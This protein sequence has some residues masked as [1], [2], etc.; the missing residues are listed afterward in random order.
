[1]SV[2]YLASTSRWRASLLR[3]CGLRVQ[4]ISP[5]IDEKSII[6]DSPIDTAILRAHAKGKSVLDQVS[7]DAI[8][9][10][11]DQVVYIDGEI[12]GKPKDPNTW[13]ARLKKFQGRGH[14]LTTAVSLFVANK[15]ITFQ[16]HSTVF[17]H[18]QASAE[19]LLDYIQD[20]EAQGCAGGYMV[21]QKGAWLIERVEG[22][23]LNV[24]GLPIF[25]ILRQLRELGWCGSDCFGQGGE[26]GV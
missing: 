26:D 17:F 14:Q 10:S 18:E 9:I 19:E 25:A 5:Q 13:L 24:I 7:S 15:E 22:D 3:N 8:V 21:E 23:W 6:G 16:E 1:M 2:I 20:G 4:T 12:F 11:A